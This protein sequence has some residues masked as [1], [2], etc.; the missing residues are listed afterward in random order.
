MTQHTHVN[1]TD[2]GGG[3]GRGGGEGGGEQVHQGLMVLLL[4]SFCD[5][6]HTHINKTHNTH[7]SVTI[8][9]EGSMFIVIY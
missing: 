3:G 6:T 8:M 5:T 2:N 7:T 9:T 4:T 1:K